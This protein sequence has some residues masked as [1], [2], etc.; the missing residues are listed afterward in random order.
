MNVLW[1][2]LTFLILAIA[3]FFVLRIY[4]RHGEKILIPD[5]NDKS[6]QSAQAIAAQ[7]GFTLI[8]NDSIFRV[9]KP[10]GVIINQNPR[11]SSFAKTGRTIY[12]TVTKFSADKLDIASLPSLYGKNF[13][14]KKKILQE[15]Y[16]INSVVVGH[17]YD[18]GEDG[19]ILKVMYGTDTI[20]DSHGVRNNYQIPKGATLRFILSTHEGGKV[21]IP[22]LVCQSLE[23]AQFIASS[24]GIQLFIKGDIQTG[25]IVNQEPAFAPGQQIDKG[26]IITVT[27][28]EERPANCPEES[29]PTGDQ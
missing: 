23:S 13:D 12:V 26:E 4:T 29:E 21:S 16:E 18:P 7:S 10:G 19:S 27:L 3:A 9:D 11:A 17:L 25:Y 22:D 1:I 24:S 15:G 8:V 2:V 20:I 5:L 6:I 14:L 28:S